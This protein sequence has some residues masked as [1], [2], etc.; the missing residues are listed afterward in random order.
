VLSQTKLSAALA[1]SLAR[2]VWEGWT[3]QSPSSLNRLGCMCSSTF[4]LA[5]NESVENHCAPPR[6]LAFPANVKNIARDE[7]NAST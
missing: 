7:R 3:T 5:G 2:E 1:P 6:I 4:R